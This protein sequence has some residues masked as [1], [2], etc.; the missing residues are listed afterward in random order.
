MQSILQTFPFD[1]KRLIPSLDGRTI[2]SET[3]LQPEKKLDVRYS[4]NNINYNNIRSSH[5][6]CY[7]YTLAIHLLTITRTLPKLYK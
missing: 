3:V 7:L 5:S 2:T 4:K 6:E 1:I